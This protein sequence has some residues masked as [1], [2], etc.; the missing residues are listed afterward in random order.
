[1]DPKLNFLFALLAGIIIISLAMSLRTCGRK[2][3]VPEYFTRHVSLDTAFER[4]AG[5]DAF[6]FAF[7]TAD[8]CPNCAKLKNG[9]LSSSSIADWAAGYSIPIYVDV[10]K[11]RSGDV[12]QQVLCSKYR[13]TELPTVILFDKGQEVGRQTGYLPRRQLLKWLRTFSDPPPS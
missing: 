13:V 3:P 8:W 1:V 9:P 6:V 10:S 12:D 5:E 4:A 11:A 7:F 2:P